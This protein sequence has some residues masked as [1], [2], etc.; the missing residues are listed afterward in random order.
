MDEYS[1]VNGKLNIEALLKMDESELFD[2]LYK[3]RI[4]DYIEESKN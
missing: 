3:G 1:L 2:A 4:Y